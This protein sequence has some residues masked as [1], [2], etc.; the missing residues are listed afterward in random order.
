MLIL[1]AHREFYE[2]P[3]ADAG[4]TLC[5]VRL[6]VVEPCGSGDVQVDPRGVVD[7]FAQEPGGADR[8]APSAA[9]VGE[10]GEGALE[11]LVRRWSLLD[12]IDNDQI[13]WSLFRFQS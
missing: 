12:S 10:V 4:W 2:R 8:S 11:E 5:H 3:H 7:E 6:R 1:P 13:N 9:D